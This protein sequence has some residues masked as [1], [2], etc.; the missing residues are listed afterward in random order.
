[1]NVLEK[2]KDKFAIS[3]CLPQD[4]FGFQ[5]GLEL[6]DFRSWETAELH[7]DCSFTPS[8]SIC[9]WFTGAV[10][11]FLKWTFSTTEG[12]CSHLHRQPGTRE[13]EVEAW[14]H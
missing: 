12:G 11:C 8:L 4:C 14:M 3:Q 1:M 7:L 2:A 6:V 9:H 10:C 5:G 13:G